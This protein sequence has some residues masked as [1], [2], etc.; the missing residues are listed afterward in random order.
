MAIF[1]ATRLVEVQEVLGID[2][3]ATFGAIGGH[4]FHRRFLEVCVP[5]IL[6]FSY[7]LFFARACIV[8]VYARGYVRACKHARTRNRIHSVRTAQLL[9]LFLRVT[10]DRIHAQHEVIL[11]EHE[12]VVF[13]DITHNLLA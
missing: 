9:D 4:L 7:L 12:E 2:A 5:S 11:G 1:P 13:L 8:R 3:V 10:G 6:L